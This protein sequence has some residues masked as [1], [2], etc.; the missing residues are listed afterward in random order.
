MPSRLEHGLY[1][2]IDG[3]KNIFR[4]IYIMNSP[5]HV[6]LCQKRFLEAVDPL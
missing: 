4:C 6:F 1:K 3:L 2:K 5:V